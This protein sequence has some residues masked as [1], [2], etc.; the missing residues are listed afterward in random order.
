MP[1]FLV[2]NFSYDVFAGALSLLIATIYCNCFSASNSLRCALE[3]ATWG[4]GFLE[5]TTFEAA[6]AA[7]V[8]KSNP[9]FGNREA[10]A[11]C[12]EPE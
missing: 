10:Q 1:K 3:K 11:D 6:S 2:L 4:Y 12:V 5:N 8:A 7:P 9:K